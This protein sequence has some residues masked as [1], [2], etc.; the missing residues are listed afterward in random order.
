MKRIAVDHAGR[1]LPAGPPEP[2]GLVQKAAEHGS[3]MQAL[4]DLSDSMRDDYVADCVTHARALAELLLAGG[5]SPWIG[6]LRVIEQRPIGTFHV[7][8]IPKRFPRR[9]WNT[10]YVCCLGDDAYDPIAGTPLPVDAYAMA[11][12]GREIAVE[13]YLDEEETAARLRDGRRLV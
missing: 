9:T 3:V 4:Q 2:S 12:F 1:D 11:V 13:R 7:P 5:A 6:R 10:H 8:L